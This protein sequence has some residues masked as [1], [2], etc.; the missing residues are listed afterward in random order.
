MCCF[1]TGGM[2]DELT[3]RLE[4][5]CTW[6]V[7]IS[8]WMMESVVEEEESAFDSEGWIQLLRESVWQ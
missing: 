3:G 6:G 8:W 1:V 5:P 2:L 7:V 4:E